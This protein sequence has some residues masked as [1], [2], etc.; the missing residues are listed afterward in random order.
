MGAEVSINE[1]LLKTKISQ[2]CERKEKERKGN[3]FER[4]KYYTRQK[5]R[6]LFD[7]VVAF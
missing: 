3:K 4:S 7:Y 6:R 5:R 2:V 1:N